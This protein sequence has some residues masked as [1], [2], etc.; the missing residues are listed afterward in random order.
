MPTTK[1]ISSRAN[2]TF[3]LLKSL[4]DS[5]GIRKHG[6]AL[7]SGRRIID[8]AVSAH[9]EKCVALVTRRGS[10]IPK[11]SPA[12]V[13]E[14]LVRYDLA[15]K[16]FDEIDVWN[17]TDYLVLVE[18]GEFPLW[19]PAQAHEGC[20]LFIAFQDP[21][22]IGAVIRSAAA[23]GVSGIVFLDEA[24]HPFHPKSVRA[25]SGNL[26]SVRMFKGPSINDLEVSGLPL[27]VLDME[28]EDIRSFKPPERFGLL[29]GME[30]P[31]LPDSLTSLSGIHH[32]RIP[33]AHDVESLN[34][35]V[36]TSIALYAL[37]KPS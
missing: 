30:G 12:E 13:S 1:E 15:K 29:C 31:G 18:T 20:T 35:A 37:R 21:S 8:E 28:G 22:N 24:A 26:F 7:L 4:L 27:V 25:A 10:E 34:A 16:L 33:I 23:F 17:A 36:A 6:K 2:S 3:K 14:S 5:R 9:P 19:H 32:L 11:I